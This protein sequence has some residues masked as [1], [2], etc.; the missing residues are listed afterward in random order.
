LAK[1]AHVPGLPAIDGCELFEERLGGE[2]GSSGSCE[3]VEYYTLLEETD[4][5]E[6]IANSI[7]GIIIGAADA[8]VGV[9]EE[10]ALSER[11][12]NGTQASLAGEAFGFHNGGNLACVGTG[13]YG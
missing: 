1:V 4:R 8:R 5:V 2:G 9:I 11:S 3:A 12:G 7:V 6:I 10:S 13:S